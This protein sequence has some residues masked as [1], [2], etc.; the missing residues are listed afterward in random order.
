MSR[1][2]KC[3]L[4]VLTDGIYNK[5]GI[6]VHPEVRAASLMT[7]PS[8][9]ITLLNTYEFQSESI[10]KQVEHYFH[11]YFK[12]YNVPC[13]GSKEWFLLN[14]YQFEEIDRLAKA[15]KTVCEKY[16]VNATKH[17]CSIFGWSVLPTSNNRELEVG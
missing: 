3:Y 8:I 17:L 5:I 15:A 7:T 12:Q 16:P 9:K 10:A 4:Y 6:S 14:G 13:P 2:R 11:E 1:V